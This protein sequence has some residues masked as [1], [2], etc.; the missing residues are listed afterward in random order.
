M[1]K[2]C[3]VGKKKKKKKKKTFHSYGH[4]SYFCKEH[5]VGNGDG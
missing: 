5:A 4:K 2:E 1:S 3:L